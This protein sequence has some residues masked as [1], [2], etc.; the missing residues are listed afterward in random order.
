MPPIQ[1]VTTLIVVSVSAVALA[2]L[3][4]LV[5]LVAEA[6]RDIAE[7][8]RAHAAGHAQLQRDIEHVRQFA[9][10]IARVTSET[11][12][13]VKTVDQRERDRLESMNPQIAEAIRQMEMV[14][15]VEAAV[16]EAE[17][18]QQARIRQLA[19]AP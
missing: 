17:R 4:M 18:V 8:Q 9:E 16:R 19:R 10:A 13:T 12:M 14:A 2:A 11:N 3:A 1:R 6:Q 15:S 5:W 7:L